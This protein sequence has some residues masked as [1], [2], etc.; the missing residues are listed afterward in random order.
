MEAAHEYLK[1]AADCE[2]LAEAA[3]T[4]STRAMLLTAAKYWRRMAN[5]KTAAG[6]AVSK[7]A[8]PP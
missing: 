7:Q 5:A 1:R 4:E 2:R 3:S 8:P 6:E